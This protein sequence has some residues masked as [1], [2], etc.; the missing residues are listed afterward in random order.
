MIQLCD[1][2]NCT[3][4]SACAN[5]CPRNAI[6]MRA[7]IEGFLQP[8]I[9]EELCIDCGLCRNV[10]HVLS[11]YDFSNHK[12]QSYAA[13]AKNPEIRQRGSS[14]GMFT[15][16]ANYILAQSGCVTGAAYDTSH[17]VRHIVI[18]TVSDLLKLQGSKY[19]QSIV[20]DVYREVKQR[21]DREQKMLFVGTP[22]QV[23][24]LLKYLRRP[25]SNLYTIDL[26]CHGVPS[27]KLFA[28]YIGYLKSRYP[29]F[30]SFS[31]R[32]LKRQNCSSSS[33]FKNPRTGKITTKVLYGTDMAYYSLFIGNYVNR[34]CCYKC[35]Y[36]Q[37][38]HRVGDITLADFCGL[39]KVI[40]YEHDKSMGVS[41]V[42]VNTP[43][44]KELLDAVKN[45]I[46][47]E[48]RSV[49]ETI[50]G[51]NSQL[52]HPA[53]RPTIRDIIYK[54]IYESNWRDLVKNLN[55]PLKKRTTLMSRLRNK[56][57]KILDI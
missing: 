46:E 52:E 5:A 36:A 40:P 44:G 6:K 57:S 43:K 31:F 9:N 1:R 56:V 14:G 7:D 20:G 37:H 10:C 3:G 11:P 45:E 19:V 8:V 51:G 16:F 13:F 54:Q 18:E 39:G 29:D 26:V 4:C 50:Q 53:E 28:Y 48:E 38:E 27:P 25:Y 15:I 47:L 49:Q 35:C 34:E 22:C 42:S 21:L 32:D 55:L 23:A 30:Y 17:I 33:S 12:L 24:G 41:F 2:Y